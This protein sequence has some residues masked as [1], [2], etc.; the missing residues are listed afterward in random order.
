MGSEGWG[1]ALSGGGCPGDR[2]VFPR[3]RLPKQHRKY[4]CHQPSVSPDKSALDR[5]RDRACDGASARS[6]EIPPDDSVSLLLESEPVRSG[7][8]HAFCFPAQTIGA[9]WK[10]PST[11]AATRASFDQSAGAAGD[12][13]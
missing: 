12:T 2:F 8:L 6:V 3:S 13:L 1:G 7:V 10:Q 5:L 4:C 11:D 9:T